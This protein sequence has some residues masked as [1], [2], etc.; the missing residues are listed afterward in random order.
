ML[1]PQRYLERL[2]KV[3]RIA[4]VGEIVSFQA[5]FLSF[6]TSLSIFFYTI[7]DKIILKA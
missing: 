3:E 7:L 5:L 1:K 6:A 2:S 4:S